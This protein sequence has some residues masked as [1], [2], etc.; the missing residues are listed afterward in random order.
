M[1]VTDYW[2]MVCTDKTTKYI[3]YKTTNVEHSLTAAANN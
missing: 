1:G 2:Y 3:K